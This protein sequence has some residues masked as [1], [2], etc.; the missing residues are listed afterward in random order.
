MQGKQE[1]ELGNN[2]EDEEIKIS[3]QEPGKDW[4]KYRNLAKKKSA[5]VN[6]MSGTDRAG[7]EEEEERACGKVLWSEQ[8]DASR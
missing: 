7:A 4:N 8:V 6:M 2:K 5:N 3:A 1:C